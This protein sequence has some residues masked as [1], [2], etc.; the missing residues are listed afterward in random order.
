[1]LG[2]AGSYGSGGNNYG[3]EV[4]PV[5]PVRSLSAKEEFLASK[6]GNG[7]NDLDADDES[8]MNELLAS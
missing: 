5:R 4:V 8:L 7:G 2:E 6:Y 1:V 3:P